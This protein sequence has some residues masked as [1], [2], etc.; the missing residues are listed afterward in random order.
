MLFI[1]SKTWS[2][3]VS[4]LNRIQL[5]DG[6]Q[7]NGLVPVIRSARIHCFGQ[8]FPMVEDVREIEA[9][10][11]NWSESENKT[12]YVPGDL[13]FLDDHVLFLIFEDQSSK[14][15]LVRAGIV[16][17]A[18]TSLPFN[19]LDSFCSDIH[20]LLQ[21]EDRQFSETDWEHG[22]PLVPDGFKQFISSQ[23]ADALFTSLRRE[24]AAKRIVGATILEDGDA[25]LFLRRAREAHA[26]GYAAK[27]LTGESVGSSLD[28]LE[29]A[30]LVERQVQV[31]CR[32]T[33]HALLRLPTAQALAVVTVSDATCSECGA[34]VADEKVE[35]VIVPT[36]LAESL[37]EDSSWLVSRF[38]QVLRELGIPESEIA[39]GPS[40][41]EGYGQIMA[42]ICGESF[43]LVMRD[44]DL[45]PSLARWAIDRVIET[46]ASHLLVVATGRLHNHAAALLHNHA[47][48]RLATGRDFELILAD[49]VASASQELEEAF[50]RV[51]HRVITEQVCD[52]DSSIGISMSHLIIR[53]FRLSQFEEKN[54]RSRLVSGE[55]PNDAMLSSIALTAHA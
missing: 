12:T 32:K 43:L 30:D 7:A 38:H 5:L 37:L 36:R 34:P 31:S 39:V 33:G 45:T 23:D 21:R 54:R 41:T 52:L 24:T 6:L 44:G 48:R 3:A 28:K 26:E 19:K 14:G 50:E 51:S 16:Y 4:G 2:H 27:L 1:E 35:E 10:V 17:E 42:N 18:S 9:A 20:R 8:A 29:D 53:R 22:R 47:R 13:F 46:E 49:G 25:R 40:G 55:P 15:P 11:S